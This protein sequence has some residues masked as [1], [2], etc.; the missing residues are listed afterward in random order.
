MDS[1]C[2]QGW[3][4]DRGLGWEPRSGSG[5]VSAAHAPL[6]SPQGAKYRGSIHDF[7]NFDPS[8]DAEALYTAMK[9]IGECPP[10][11][12]GTGKEAGFA[13]ACGHSPEPCWGWG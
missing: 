11:G 1:A 9:G 6:F 2:G 8:Q 12:V 7:P 5:S 10:L 3:E 4:Y 13:G